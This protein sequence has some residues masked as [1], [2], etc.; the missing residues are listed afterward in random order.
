MGYSIETS[1]TKSGKFVASV[2]TGA[3][4]RGY[5][6]YTSDA[7]D[8]VQEAYKDA[9]DWRAERAAANVK[10]KTARLE[11][12][13]T[14]QCCAGKYL[15]NTGKMAHHGY[16]RPGNGWQTASCIGARELPF[17]VSRD[18]LG[19]LIVNLE[20]Q[21]VRMIEFRNEIATEATPIHRTFEDR[22]K[23]KAIVYPYKCPTVSFDITRDNYADIALKHQLYDDFDGFLAKEL[24]TLNYQ[25]KS[26]QDYIIECKARYA[27]WSQTHEWNKKAKEWK[28]I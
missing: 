8:T 15:A 22:S 13:M 12:T 9:V 21:A 20:A 7:K 25:I 2:K 14:C 11:A 1:K 5:A 18:R 23:P 17:E 10:I 16:Q 4:G 24:R 27:G 3:Y 28:I 26:I 6:V 19:E